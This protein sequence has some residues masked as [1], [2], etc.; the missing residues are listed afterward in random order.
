MELDAQRGAQQK[1][2]LFHMELESGTRPLEGA[3]ASF[4][5][6]WRGV[7]GVGRD[8]P[9][10]LQAMCMLFMQVRQFPFLH[11]PSLTVSHQAPV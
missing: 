4:G 6:C 7:R 11:L 1:L 10:M 9:L 8:S 2:I 3:R 5:R